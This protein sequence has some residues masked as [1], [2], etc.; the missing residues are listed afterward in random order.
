QQL[1]PQQLMQLQQQQQFMHQQQQHNHYQQ[2]YAPP[3]QPQHQY[4]PQ[5]QGPPP[6]MGYPQQPPYYNAQ[7]QQPP[8]PLQRPGSINMG[9]MMNPPPGF[10]VSPG[11]PV[12][13]VSGMGVYPN[14]RPQAAIP[15]PPRNTV[16]AAPTA[17]SAQSTIAPSS[18][19]S[20]AGPQQQGVS[21]VSVGVSSTGIIR[22]GGGVGQLFPDGGSS[23]SDY[24]ES[25]TFDSHHPLPYR[26]P[27]TSSP[28]LSRSGTVNSTFGGVNGP[29]SP[30]SSTSVPP[31]NLG[32][33]PGGSGATRPVL[34]VPNRVTS[35]K[36]NVEELLDLGAALFAPPRQAFGDAF[37]KW[38][39]AFDQAQKD[40]DLFS[41]VRAL[42]NMGCAKRAMNSLEEALA[43][44][45]QSW[46]LSLHYLEEKQI[47]LGVSSAS[48]GGDAAAASQWAESQHWLGIVLRTL[49]LDDP[50]TLM[51]AIAEA[52]F[53][54]MTMSDGVDGAGGSSSMGGAPSY[55]AA[56]LGKAVG[57]RNASM[58]SNGS[59]GSHNSNSSVDPALGPPVVVW[60]MRLTT[61]LGNAYYSLGKIEKAM[62]WHAKCLQ[63]AENVLDENPLPPQFER[64]LQEVAGAG[65]KGNSGNINSNQKV[66]LS[67]LHR[68]TILAQARALSHIGICCQHLGLDDN[69]L[70]CHSHAASLLA[71]YSARSVND[72]GKKENPPAT[73][74]G[75][76]ASVATTST[77]STAV[78][79][80]PTS[81]GQQQGSN[82]STSTTK[83]WQHLRMDLHQAA[84][85]ANLATSYFAKGRLPAAIE[86]LERAAKQYSQFGDSLGVARSLC[87]LGALRIE[88][89][90]TLGA[91]HW[92]RNM[93]IQAVGA[94]EVNECLRYWGPPRLAGMNLN[95]GEWDESASIV[96]G[97]SWVRDV[98]SIMLEQMRVLKETGDLLGV[99]T[100]LLNI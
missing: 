61:N 89:G 79:S 37:V 41:Q 60:F 62:N 66:K 45:K 28:N 80:N 67:Y 58:K 33:G 3:Q 18:L 83:V 20:M 85:S 72:D 82:S 24:S 27:G 34:I 93:E 17:S 47:Q 92:I 74:R 91:L 4:M 1:T 59:A 49:D 63:L 16:K 40:D 48:G 23:S 21:G 57:R 73:K 55:T 44:Q 12:P 32:G 39:Q 35:K 99:L 51:A 13:P 7:Q 97:A 96:A 78:N 42:S 50:D 25:P 54:A 88:V 22:G 8:P 26:G 29:S 87:S 43:L 52:E 31:S 30:T 10:S 94:G 81:S 64:N 90:K 56:A 98:I 68:A 69:A 36:K 84:V 2:Q 38:E 6:G 14:M 77:A 65:M 15:I 19:G 11:G 46:L 9:V 100:A 71:F 5:Q 95:S 70:Q 75:S 86:R 76:T 53:E